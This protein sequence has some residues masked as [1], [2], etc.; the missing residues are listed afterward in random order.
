MK[1]WYHRLEYDD[2][3]LANKN[4]YEFGLGCA[5]QKLGLVVGKAYQLE[6]ILE[7]CESVNLPF[8]LVESVLI[9]NGMLGF[10]SIGF[11]LRM[12][13][14]TNGPWRKCFR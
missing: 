8:R 12:W 10:P 11:R 3:K 2:F 7:R 4:G 1:N 5:C 9:E 14:Y 6:D 13:R